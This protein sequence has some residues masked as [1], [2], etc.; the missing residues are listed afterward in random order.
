MCSP[1]ELAID[2][3]RIDIAKQL[4][5][6]GANP[7][8]PSLNFDDTFGVVQLLD[9]Y[10][11]FGTNTFISWLLH[12]HLLPQDIPQFIEN[13]MKCNIINESGIKMFIKAGRHP[14]HALLTCGN[15]EI[16][17][18]FLK[19]N[20]IRVN[21]KDEFGRTALRVATENCDLHSVKVL[22]KFYLG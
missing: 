13:V 20:S 12:Q 7:I 16:V 22:L 10:Y 6:H 4:V 18:Q 21:V 3:R 2:S 5:M 8:H 17:T 9:E 15:E 19:H 11:M 14:A 1:I